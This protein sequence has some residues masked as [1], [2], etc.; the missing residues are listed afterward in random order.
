MKRLPL[1]LATL[2]LLSSPGYAQYAHS[3]ADRA[4][5]ARQFAHSPADRAWTAQQESVPATT[6]LGRTGSIVHNSTLCGPDPLNCNN[7][8]NGS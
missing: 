7:S 4:W 2:A 5:T 6:W 3:H 1:A 8:A